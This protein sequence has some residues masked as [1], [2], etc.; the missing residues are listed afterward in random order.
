VTITC[1]RIDS[2]VKMVRGVP[3]AKFPGFIERSGPSFRCP[4][5]KIPCGYRF[6]DWSPERI[7]ERSRP[8]PQ[9]LR[10]N[11]YWEATLLVWEATEAYNLKIP[12]ELYGR[13]KNRFMPEAIGKGTTVQTSKR[14]SGP[15]YELPLQQSVS[16][17]GFVLWPG[18][19]EGHLAVGVSGA[20]TKNRSRR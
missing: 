19:R 16:Q 17:T 1:C 9:G 12:S 14:I 5:A 8:R 11:P 18:A 13:P 15:S 3:A 4:P 7:Y 6:L 2:V 10:R 20:P